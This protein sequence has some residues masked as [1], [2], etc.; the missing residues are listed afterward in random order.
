LA[1]AVVHRE[2]VQ[3]RSIR[4]IAERRPRDP[5]LTPWKKHLAG[6][7]LQLAG[8]EAEGF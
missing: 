5:E 2:G 1:N 7:E 3:A 4:Y 6:V 8:H